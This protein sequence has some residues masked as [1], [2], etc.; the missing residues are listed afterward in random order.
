MK[1]DQTRCDH[2]RKWVYADGALFTLYDLVLHHYRESVA[3]CERCCDNL[4]HT[5]EYWEKWLDNRFAE[6]IAVD[7]YLDRATDLVTE[8]GD[9]ADVQQPYWMM[10]DGGTTYCEDCV[11]LQFDAFEPCEYGEQYDGGF[12]GE[13]DGSNVC[14]TCG[15]LLEYTLTSEGVN[16]ELE[17]F[18]EFPFNRDSVDECYA[19]ARIA[20]GAYTDKQKGRLCNVLRS[21]VNQPD[22]LKEQQNV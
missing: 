18:E 19:M 21:S 16:S 22:Q 20:N 2:C 14:D 8:R 6:Q 9:K 11:K 10:D 1:Q 4:K 5:S 13:E 17:H 15:Q 7:E 3:V 12:S